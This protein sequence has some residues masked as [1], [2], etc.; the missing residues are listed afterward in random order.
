MVFLNHHVP[1]GHSAVANFLKFILFDASILVPTFADSIPLYSRYGW[2]CLVEASVSR[3]PNL[4]PRHCLGPKPKAPM[5]S[6]VA[7]DLPGILFS[8]KIAAP[9][10]HCLAR[11]D[12][13]SLNGWDLGQT[14]EMVVIGRD[15]LTVGYIICILYNNYNIHPSR[16]WRLTPDSFQAGR[17]HLV[18]PSFRSHLPWLHA[19]MPELTMGPSAWAPRCRHQGSRDVARRQVSR[20]WLSWLS[21]LEDTIRRLRWMWFSW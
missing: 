19:A 10:C 6:E 16:K 9:N 5:T 18:S 11:R 1:R 2:V 15:F 17:V 3:S 14:T 4:A 8:W 7:F 13:G 21:W 12:N 20:P